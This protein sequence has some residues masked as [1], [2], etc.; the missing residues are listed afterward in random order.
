[1]NT[2][3][4]DPGR[5]TG[6]FRVVPALIGALLF[7]AALV[8]A[9]LYRRAAG[10]GDDL[11]PVAAQ[12]SGRLGQTTAVEGELDPPSA[13]RVE[14]PGRLASRATGGPVH[15]ADDSEALGTTLADL[16]AELE[17]LALRPDEFH[18]AALPLV[19]R[20]EDLC[21]RIPATS[22]ESN[23]DVRSVLLDP[24][25]RNGLA[26]PLV[27]GAVFL[28]LASPLPTDAFRETFDVWMRDRLLPLELVRAAALGAVL[29]G[30]T[31]PC[32]ARID[33]TKLQQLPTDGTVPF[34]NVYP[35]SM[36]SVV[37][38][39][40][41]AVIRE[42]IT[43]FDAL[44]DRLERTQLAP[45]DPDLLIEA[46]E[47]FVAREVLLLTLGHRSIVD[48]EL[49]AFVLSRAALDGSS[50]SPVAV[51]VRAAHFV[52]N[53]LSNCSER[54][55]DF[56]SESA[57]SDSPIRSGLTHMMQD[58]SVGPLT[59]EN[60]ARLQSLRHAES[61]TDASLFMLEISEIAERL[62]A[63]EEGGELYR[64][65]YVDFLGEIAS[66]PI[67]PEMV[68]MAAMN[69]LRVA[70]EWDA[71]VRA[72]STILGTDAPLHLEIFALA[73]LEGAAEADDSLHPAIRRI[74][75]RLQEAG[76]DPDLAPQIESCRLLLDSE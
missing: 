52:V 60:L 41:A 74:L 19:R 6:R 48:P 50:G 64:G 26:D 67:E 9:L 13:R 46:G 40:E 62:A 53:S 22:I 66:D 30:G 69:G 63:E 72:A 29:R 56:I 16:V 32:D 23:E 2:R 36:T 43:D 1:M 75:D 58:A 68:R 5:G 10:R 55:L 54:Y 7:A 57:R 37:G 12:A 11:A 20:I 33:L 35:L 15:P 8:A 31:S 34:P 59:L 51:D 4:P 47:S 49:E 42:R 71:A 39:H 3:T 44:I 24:V 38:D 65:Q 73:A 76:F 61:D 18:A 14:T 28:G 70:G 25:V 17:R 21:A 45:R 27:R